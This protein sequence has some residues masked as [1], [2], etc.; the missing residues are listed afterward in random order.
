MTLKVGVACIY[1]LNSVM[2][3]GLKSEKISHLPNLVLK[4]AN[5]LLYVIHTFGDPKLSQN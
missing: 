5:A 2:T 3:L 1:A 4:K